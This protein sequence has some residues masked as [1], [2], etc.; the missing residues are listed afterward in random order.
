MG[1]LNACYEYRSIKKQIEI[2]A[3]PW[4]IS[5]QS[6]LIN[7]NAD[8][9]IQIIEKL[10]DEADKLRVEKN[11]FLESSQPRELSSLSCSQNRT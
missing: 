8:S 7:S 9:I 11:A 6:S 4:V 1:V 2:A 5:L 3:K 10:A